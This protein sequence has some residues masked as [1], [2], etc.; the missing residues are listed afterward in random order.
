[1]GFKSL[2][3][4]GKEIEER[5]K[6]S[7]FINDDDDINTIVTKS[8]ALEIPV[9]KSAIACITDLIASLNVQLYQENNKQI[10]TI[11][12]YR[13]K[14]LN[15]ETGDTLNSYQMK[16]S[17]IKDF[18]LDGHGY[19]FVKKYRNI[20]KSLHYIDTSEI[21]VIY[22]SDP[23]NKKGIITIQGVQY[24]PQDFILMA[25]NSKKG[26]TGRGILDEN[27]RIISLTYNTLLFS[28][29]NIN[30]G[31]IKRGVVKSEKPLGTEAM[32]ALK[33][34]WKNLYNKNNSS[35]CIILNDGLSF[36]ELSQTA[37]ELEVLETRAKNDEDILNILKVPHSVLTGTATDSV[38]NNFIKTTI[39]PILEQLQNAINKSLLLEEEKDNGYFFAFDTKELL[40]GSISERFNA[41]KT[42]IDAGVMTVN[43]CRYQENLD[44][45]DGLDVV[46]MSLGNVLFDINTKNIYVPNTGEHI[47]S[48]LKGGELKNGDKETG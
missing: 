33:T 45:I 16:A 38:Y 41:Y 32:N 48:N 3:G 1:M 24:E 21:E 4:F 17:F 34:G 11:D 25:Q 46:K 39:I 30:A 7:D 19:I 20:I 28:E 37:T 13:L 5:S 14:L 36:Q 22:N 42:A 23:I 44:L 31:G 2:F 18:L 35:S 29:D 15:E 10:K 47:T 43:E 26:L 8:E 9:L 12:D 40:K 6:L 27:D